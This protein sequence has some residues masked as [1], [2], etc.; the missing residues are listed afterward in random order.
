MIIFNWN[1]LDSTT[2]VLVFKM[3]KPVQKRL[4]KRDVPYYDVIIDS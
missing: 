1:Y 4:L 3:A 2:V